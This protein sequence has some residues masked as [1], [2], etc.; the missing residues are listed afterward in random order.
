MHHRKIPK[1]CTSP[2][3]LGSILVTNSQAASAATNNTSPDDWVV[4]QKIW[5]AT[6]VTTNNGTKQ[7]KLATLLQDFEDILCAT[8]SK[9][10]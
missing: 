1:Q 5:G 2:H 8:G 4:H 6:L 3:T 7:V 9:S 10:D